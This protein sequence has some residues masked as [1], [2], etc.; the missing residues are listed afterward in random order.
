MIYQWVDPTLSWNPKDYDDVTTLYVPA[1][2][3]WH[4]DI[5]LYNTYVAYIIVRLQQRTGMI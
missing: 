5:V 4:P 2:S 3:I 1:V